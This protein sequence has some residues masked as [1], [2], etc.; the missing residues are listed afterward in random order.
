M[1]IASYIYIYQ[2]ESCIVL[3][4]NRKNKIQFSKTGYE[5]YNIF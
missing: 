2:I 5:R 4:D 3:E 1:Q